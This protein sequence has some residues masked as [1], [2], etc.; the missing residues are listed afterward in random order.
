MSFATVG[1]TS[2]GYAHPRVLA[3]QMNKTY[4][5]ITPTP[6]APLHVVSRDWLL[7]NIGTDQPQLPATAPATAPALALAT[8]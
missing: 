1:T 3:P 2:S 6:T 7:L 8:A 5:S 4:M